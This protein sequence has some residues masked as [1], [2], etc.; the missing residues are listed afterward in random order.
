MGQYSYACDHCRREPDQFEH[1]HKAAVVGVK[2]TAGARVWLKGV[3]NGYGEVQVNCKGVKPVEVT[4]GQYQKC[5]PVWTHK[6]IT[7]VAD[8]VV[9]WR[10]V[11]GNTAHCH[12]DFVAI[13]R[14]HNSFQARGIT[15]RILTPKLWAS[16]ATWGGA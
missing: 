16:L 2:D 13:T 15:S 11:T 9:C 5:F 12:G 1:V 14:N 3:Y 10:C 6:T 7:V 8:E 4:L